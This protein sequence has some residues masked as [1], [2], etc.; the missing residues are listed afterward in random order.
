MDPE[1]LIV[2]PEEMRATLDLLDRA[3]KQDESTFYRIPEGWIPPEWR[4]EESD[5]AE[6]DRR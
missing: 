4:K 6:L 2:T 3:I 5:A 1:Q